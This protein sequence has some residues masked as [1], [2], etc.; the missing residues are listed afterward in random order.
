MK[1]EKTQLF[2]ITSQTPLSP[3]PFLQQMENQ[4][5]R[6]AFF[7]VN[8]SICLTL[9][10]FFEKKIPEGRDYYFLMRIYSWARASIVCLFFGARLCVYKWNEF[11]FS[12][13]NFLFFKFH[14]PLWLHNN[15]LQFIIRFLHRKSLPMSEFEKTKINNSTIER[16]ENKRKERHFFLFFSRSRPWKF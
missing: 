9:S 12:P 13:P 2:L 3:S 4:I 10:S 11:F 7:D 1:Y 8:K 16:E 14:P 15:D 5:R 6:T